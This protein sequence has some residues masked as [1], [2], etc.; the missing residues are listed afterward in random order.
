M[1]LPGPATI[2][3]PSRPQNAY[4]IWLSENR[5]A[6]T[7]EAGNGSA[8]VVGRLAGDRWKSMTSKQ[9]LPY[10]KKAEEKKAA[11]EKAMEEFKAAGGV[12]GKRRQEK[13]EAKKARL[14]KK[15]RK[16]ARK[17]SDKPKKPAS[18]YWLW[19]CENRAALTKE[20]GQG[21]VTMVSKLGGERW[22][23]LSAA[24]KAPFEKKAAELKAEYDKAMAEWKEKNAGA[25]ADEGEDEND[26]DDE[27]DED[28]DKEN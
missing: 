8:G 14:D 13:A 25:E 6:L 4:W 15:A 21:K 22:R 28:D 11:Y 12:P 1:P 24:A 17:N 7:K 27:D 9:K 19:L 3:E 10:E 26:E 23:A 2:Q 16:E 18:G 20:V 5:P